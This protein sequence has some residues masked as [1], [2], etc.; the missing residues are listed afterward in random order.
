[1]IVMKS[2]EFDDDDKLDAVLPMV[3]PEKP[4]YPY[5]LRICLTEKELDKL[6]IDCAEACVGG[7]F[8]GHFMAKIT[9]VSTEERAGGDCCRLEAQIT[10][11]AIES[12]DEENDEAEK[13]M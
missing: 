11:L 6:G 2:M 9:S 1:M 3:M 7:T 12:E 13:E 5:G 4:D 8:H 10:D